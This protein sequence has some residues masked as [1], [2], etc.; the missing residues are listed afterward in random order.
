[1]YCN[2]LWSIDRSINNFAKFGIEWNICFGSDF[3][4]IFYS[5]HFVYVTIS[6]VETEKSENKRKISK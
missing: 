5:I 1:M 3:N 4:Y 2:A 6:S